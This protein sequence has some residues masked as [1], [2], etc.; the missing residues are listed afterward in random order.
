MRST[1]ETLATLNSAL[2][3]QRMGYR[4]QGGKGE[5]FWPHAGPTGDGPKVPPPP[6]SI[7]CCEADVLLTSTLVIAHPYM[8]LFLITPVIPVCLGH[9]PFPLGDL[10]SLLWHGTNETWEDGGR[11]SAQKHQDLLGDSRGKEG[12]LQVCCAR[13]F[14][15]LRDTVSSPMATS[16]H[17][18]LMVVEKSSRF[19]FSI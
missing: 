9:H 14:L 5:K 13:P 4:S 11:G 19:W 18:G 3:F 15:V 2:K 7:L 17:M 16:N 8:N 10:S 1:R 6:S 12:F